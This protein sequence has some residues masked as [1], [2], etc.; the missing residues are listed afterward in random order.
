MGS[1]TFLRL[2]SEGNKSGGVGSTGFWMVVPKSLVPN[3]DTG[4]HRALRGGTGG[5]AGVICQDDTVRGSSQLEAL[6]I[7][8]RQM[9]KDHARLGVTVI[10]DVRG[11]N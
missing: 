4:Q 6:G 10:P 9:N 2:R 11:G 1:P 8:K 7:R 5:Q 3:S